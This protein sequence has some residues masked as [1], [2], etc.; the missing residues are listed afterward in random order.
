MYIVPEEGAQ[1]RCGEKC[2]SSDLVGSW[3]KKHVSFIPRVSRRYSW[4]NLP[5]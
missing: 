3:L 2:W 5:Y 4:K 1:A